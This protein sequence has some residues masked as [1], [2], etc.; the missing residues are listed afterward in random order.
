M[1]HRIRPL[2]VACAFG[3][4]A[5][6]ASAQVKIGFIGTLSGSAAALGQDQYDGF[7]L[8]VAQRGGKLGGVPV[9]VLKEDDQLKPDLAVQVVQ[10]L[11]QKDKVD[12][13]T[14]VTFSN[15]MMALAKPLAESG[16]LF[17]GSNA[18]P[19][20][21]AGKQCH[22]N[23]FFTSFQ[24]DN[25][26]EVLGKYAADKGYRKMLLLAPNYQSGKDQVLGFKRY[27]KGAVAGEIYTQ[28]N[29]PD[30]SAELAQ[31][32]AAAP[33][34]I[35]AF[36]PGGMGVN[37]IKQMNQSGLLH[38]VPLLTVSTVDGTTL[39]AI[40]D[41]ALDVLAGAA[42]GPDLPNPANAAFVAA[43]EK[44]H[45]RIPSQYA[46]QGFDAALAIDSALARTQGAVANRDA[47]RAALAAADFASVRSGF[48][49]AANGFPVQDQH[50]FVVAKDAQGRVSLKKIATPLPGL[51]DAYAAECPA[52]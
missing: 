20:P 13:V 27:Y 33:D 28:L 12:L 16:L 10:K 19:A 26:A 31:I 48:K 52:K 11:I 14:G 9:T 6:A 17:V 45:G 39:P 4:A 18:G 1:I 3:L 15:V 37:F 21:L 47:L 49:F 46:A 51:V 5:V 8:A 29:Q 22:P 40:K 23:F 7:M 24:N 32:Q 43:F 50:V 25:Q 42:W 35:F 34:A 2:L 30:Y 36:F 38:K 44:K 41:A